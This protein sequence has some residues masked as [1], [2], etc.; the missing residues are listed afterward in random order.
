[1]KIVKA[2]LNLYQRGEWSELEDVVERLI[3]GVRNRTVGFF[4]V[5][6]LADDLSSLLTIQVHLNPRSGVVFTCPVSELVATRVESLGSDVVASLGWRPTSSDKSRKLE[7]ALHGRQGERFLSKTFV[8][9][10]QLMV[11]R[12]ENP[13]LRLEVEGRVSS[14]ANLGEFRPHPHAQSIFRV[15]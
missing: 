14:P 5:S 13:W 12:G 11:G 2:R 3:S 15:R 1:M 10:L 9:W 8:D 6:A 4:S 7:F